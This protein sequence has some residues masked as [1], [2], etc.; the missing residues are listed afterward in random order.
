MSPEETARP[1]GAGVRSQQGFGSPWLSSDPTLQG[2]TETPGQFHQHDHHEAVGKQGA[3]AGQHLS[4]PAAP[5]LP[6]SW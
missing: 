4:A 1:S 5:H 6:A 2:E 3:L